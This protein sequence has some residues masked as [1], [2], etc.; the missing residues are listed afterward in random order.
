MILEAFTRGNLPT[1]DWAGTRH[2]GR[3]AEGQGSPPLLL[4]SLDLAS[5]EHPH[6][7]TRSDASEARE[8]SLERVV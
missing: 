5:N 1:A 7:P 2:G 3:R 8:R 4:N 6:N